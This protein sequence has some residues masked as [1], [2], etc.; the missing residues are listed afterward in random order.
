MSEKARY[1]L[2]QQERGIS[3][4]ARSIVN[5][6]AGFAADNYTAHVSISKLHQRTFIRD[7]RTLKANLAEAVEAG[8]LVDTGRKVRGTPVYQ[9]LC[10]PGAV[11]AYER[12]GTTAHRPPTLEE[13]LA[14]G[15]FVPR[16]VDNFDGDREFTVPVDECGSDATCE[17]AMPVTVNVQRPTPCEFTVQTTVDL[18]VQEREKENLDKGEIDMGGSAARSPAAPVSQ[19]DCEFSLSER[20]SI[21]RLMKFGATQEGAEGL[22]VNRNG[23]YVT[24]LDAQAIERE[25]RAAGLGFD[26]AVEWAAF[27][28]K[29]TFTRGAYAAKGCLQE[30]GVQEPQASPDDAELDVIE[31][32]AGGWIPAARETTT[33]GDPVDV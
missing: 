22:V 2:D 20:E 26:K 31:S 10:P 19:A 4:L 12:D 25:A 9:M 15:G 30:V 11:V 21:G 23:S 32:L 28:G 6:Y 1:W 8:Y 5:A 7:Y 29:A 24:M 18:Q 3:A 14:G 33:H 16:N 27:N 17:Y 13:Y